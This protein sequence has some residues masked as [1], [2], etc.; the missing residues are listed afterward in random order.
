MVC[1]LKVFDALIDFG[2][3]ALNR[4]K[5]VESELLTMRHLACVFG[6]VCS[7]LVFPDLA[8]VTT[9]AAFIVTL[10]SSVLMF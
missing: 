8:A 2:L 6:L 4:S 5:F 10:P 3:L 7:L 9:L 1:I